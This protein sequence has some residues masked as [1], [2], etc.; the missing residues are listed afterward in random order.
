MIVVV[1]F[2]LPVFGQKISKPTLTPKP[3]TE[4]QMELLREGV[5]LHDQKEYDAA[6][7]KFELILI[8]NPDSSLAIY[9]LANSY[10]ASGK[11]QKAI[12]TAVRG[13]KYRSENLPLLYQIIASVI[14][15]VGKPNEAIKIYREAIDI[16]KKD[17]DLA[18]HLSNLYYNLG[19]TYTR[20]K[21]YKE[22]REELK[23]AIEHNYGYASPHYLLSEVYV[24]TQYKIPAFAAAI[25]LMSL[26]FNTQRSARAATIIR[27]LLQPLQKNPESGN[28]Q[29]FLNLD[30]PK[31]EGDFSMYDLFLGTLLTIK[32][33][34]DKG[35]SEHE[36]FAGAIEKL[37]ALMVGDKKL[38]KTFV[39]ENYVPFLAELK[40][41][42]FALPLTYL[43]FYNT[44]NKEAEVWIKAHPTETL[45]FIEW[46]KSFSAPAK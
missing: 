41:R 38:Q 4:A 24:G 34:K 5:I 16:L 22:A 21:L 19:V 45:A 25:R 40:K 43:I 14:D 39:G 13:T 27:S 36:L 17:K 30:A 15:D 6:I 31:D 35:K 11:T 9:E 23:Q 29:I 3:E 46:A 10:Y 33:E 37:I 8:E 42:S 32:D 18:R 12:E 28:I 1:L 2:C 26:E 44:G 7:K 20:Q